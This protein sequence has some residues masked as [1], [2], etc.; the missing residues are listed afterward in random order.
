MDTI[1]III[2]DRANAIA[3]A[4]NINNFV[5][6]NNE[7][8][9]HLPLK[10]KELLDKSIMKNNIEDIEV[11]YVGGLEAFGEY[12]VEDRLFSDANKFVNKMQALGILDNQSTIQACSLFV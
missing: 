6:S 11:V 7:T 5:L 8:I 3:Y 2:N 12:K 10:L 4:L 1:A 9:K